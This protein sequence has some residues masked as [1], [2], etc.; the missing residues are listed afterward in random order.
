MANA[1]L[2]ILARVQLINPRVR[3]DAAS[4]TP[5]RSDATRSFGLAA[6]ALRVASDLVGVNEAALDLGQSSIRNRVFLLV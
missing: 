5:P 1:R 3:V 2:P 6:Y 4:F